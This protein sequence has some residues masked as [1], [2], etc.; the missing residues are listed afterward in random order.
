KFYV[1]KFLKVDMVAIRC[2]SGDAVKF[3]AAVKKVNEI[4]KLP[5]V[6]CSLDPAVLKA[7]LEVVKDKNPLIY[8][9][10]EKN[11]GEVSELA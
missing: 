1:G 11:W 5:L 6:L 4:T 9:A 10:T 8:A 3:A 2:V 7:G